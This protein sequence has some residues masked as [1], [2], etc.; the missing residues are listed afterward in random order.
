MIIDPVESRVNQNRLQAK[1]DGMH[2]VIFVS[3]VCWYSVTFAR[4]S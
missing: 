2:L 4:A 1:V 3:Y